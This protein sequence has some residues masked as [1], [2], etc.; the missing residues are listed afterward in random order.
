M[1]FNPPIRREGVEV[2][3][4]TFVPPEIKFTLHIV[5]TI[6]DVNTLE[7]K[8]AIHARLSGMVRYLE[9]EWD[10]PK[11]VNWHYHSGVVLHKPP[12][13]DNNETVTA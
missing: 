11:N 3:S 7:M 12:G 8:A 1:I 2:N 13:D 5:G 6:E 4:V 9:K 10:I